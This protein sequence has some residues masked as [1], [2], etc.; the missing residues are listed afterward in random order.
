MDSS[1]TFDPWKSLAEL[2]EERE[3]E[4]FSPDP[5]LEKRITK[6]RMSPLAKCAPEDLLL[7][8]RHRVGLVFV[9]PLA[10]DKLAEQPFL[11]AAE[12]PGDLLTAV[13]EVPEPFWKERFEL[14][15]T[16]SSILETAMAYV[17]SARHVDM[18]LTELVGDGLAEAIL[19]FTGIHHQSEGE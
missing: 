5:A 6:I 2:E 15:K 11:Q 16:G 18:P 7:L 12:F 17:E 14:W 3:E 19:Y 1:I 10:F 8:A 13:L 4:A 9:V